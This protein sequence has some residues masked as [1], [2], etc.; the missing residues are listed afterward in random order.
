MDNEVKTP[1]PAAQKPDPRTYFA[2]ERTFLAWVRSG[3]ALMGFG[4]VL[5]RFG[6][7]LREAQ[8]LI[9]ISAGHSS[10]FSVWSGTGLVLA[11]VAVNVFSIVNYRSTIARLNRGEMTSTRPS[12]L[13]MAMALGLAVLGLLIAGSLLYFR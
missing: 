6:L 13:G 5:A 8:A 9:H 2:A 7:F 1:Q 4:F 12:A 11:G 10:K 3:L